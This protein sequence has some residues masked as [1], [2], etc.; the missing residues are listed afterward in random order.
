M[1]MVMVWSRY[2][3]VGGVGGVYRTGGAWRVAMPIGKHIKHANTMVTHTQHPHHK[4]Q[5]YRILASESLKHSAY[6][7]AMV[8]SEAA[9]TP[10][11]Q[12]QPIPLAPPTI[13]LFTRRS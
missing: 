2:H 8:S 9:P 3:L 13:L 7:S 6:T 5:H 4:F 11:P 12:H 1:V 10:H